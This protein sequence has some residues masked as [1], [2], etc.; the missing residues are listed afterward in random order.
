MGFGSKLKKAFK[1]VNDFGHKVDP[2]GHK[3][4]DKAVAQDSRNVRSIAKAFGGSKEGDG[5]AS[6]LYREA[7]R[8]VA[9]PQSAQ[10]KAAL[11]AGSIFGGAALAGA[12]AGAG[13]AAAG[14]GGGI[15][16]TAGAS[17]AAAYG[18]GGLGST[19]GTAG[20]A[21]LGAA[22]AG[23]A[24]TLAGVGGAYGAGAGAL[25]GAGAAGGAGSGLGGWYSGLEPWQQQAAQGA[26]RGG[27]NSAVNDGDPWK[28]ALMG[29]V[30]GGVGSYTGGA[31]AGAGADPWMAQAGSMGAKYL[32]GQAMQGALSQDQ[33]SPA[34]QSPY[35][36]QQ[37]R[38]TAQA[39][40]ATQ[41]QVT[42]A[43]TN[44][45]LSQKY[46]ATRAD[47]A[48]PQLSNVMMRK[49]GRVRGPLSY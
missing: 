30:T 35:F 42:G 28:G 37:A 34:Q 41:Q 14:A 10:F 15:T 24:S 43:P 31:L 45:I 39:P 47:Q 48:A 12:A 26:A 27:F 2:I 22:G 16:G 1:K 25:A 36:T 18:A 7:D 40:V 38:Q 32:A 6:S 4:V 23:G 13:G 9:D 46:F 49:G 19:L 11:V 44:D 33:P 21:S 29:A 8:N 3:I 5:W 20:T 17:G